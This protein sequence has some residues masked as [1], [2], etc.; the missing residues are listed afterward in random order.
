MTSFKLEPPVQAG[1]EYAQLSRQIK[2]AGLLER[3]PGYYLTKI[4]ANLVLLGA[5]VTAFFLL[6]DSWLQLLTAVFLAL[7]A[8]QIA[9]VSHD[10]GHRQI[11]RTRRANDLL[12]FPQANLLVGISFGWWVG[13][14]N[15]HHANP[16]NVDRDP[17]VQIGAVA[18]T[19]DQAVERRGLAR[20][21]A[22]VQAYLF[23]P[24]L[25]LE[26]AQLHAAS[27]K[28]VLRGELKHPVIEGT[29]LLVNAV[30]SLTAVFVV[31][32]PVKAIVFIAVQQGLFG[33]YLGMSFAPN[34]KGMPVLTQEQE[35]DYLRRQVLTARNVRGGRL[36]DF[37][38]GGLNYQVEHHLFPSL[39]R[40]SLRRAQPIV[41]AF[42]LEHGIAYHEATLLGS[43]AEALR[44]LHIVGEPLRLGPVS[45]E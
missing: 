6:G 45:V 21:M 2:H 8:T 18:F 19:A 32:S 31:L 36:V 41:R 40:P 39:P 1:S 10:A 5:G 33:L 17:D 44:H 28:A 24:L 29:L 26:A 12:G 20:A 7:V 37:A 35:R 25:T 22:R 11:F 42:C 13:K 23:F 14:H 30:A 34:H 43:Y 16:N 9:F 15:R 38:L 27:V 4:A 3:R